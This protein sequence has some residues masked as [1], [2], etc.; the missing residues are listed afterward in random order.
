MRWMDRGGWMA[1][2][3][4]EQWQL[5]CPTAK[6][7]GICGNLHSRLT[8]PSQQDATTP[9]WPSFARQLQL[10][11][12]DKTICTIKIR[13]QTGSYFNF[14]QRHLCRFGLDWL[15]PLRKSVLPYAR[16]NSFDRHLHR[17]PPGS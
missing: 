10:L 12:P 14:K 17:T 9:Y 7:V 13:F 5:L 8:L 2:N 1:Q 3:L 15:H 16:T 11:H 6:I 4:A